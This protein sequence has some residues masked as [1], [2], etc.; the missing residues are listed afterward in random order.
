MYYSIFANYVLFVMILPSVKLW[1]LC[2]LPIN[3]VKHCLKIYF[4]TILVVQIFIVN[5]TYCQ[6]PDDN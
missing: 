2:D 6:I 1:V 5:K 3:M 4:V